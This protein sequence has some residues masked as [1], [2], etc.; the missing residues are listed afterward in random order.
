MSEL[1]IEKRDINC[2]L[3]ISLLCCPKHWYIDISH[4]AAI[5]MNVTVN[6]VNNVEVILKIG[7]QKKMLSDYMRD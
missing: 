3:C 1:N 4:S 5:G 7:Y 6:I 2:S